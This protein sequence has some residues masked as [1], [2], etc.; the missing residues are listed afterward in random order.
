MAEDGV[1]RI[2]PLLTVRGG[3]DG[4]SA[5]HEVRWHA[6]GLQGDGMSVARHDVLMSAQC[7]AQAVWGLAEVATGLLRGEQSPEPVLQPAARR[8][9]PGRSAWVA[10]SA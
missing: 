5:V 2:E 7:P 4:G 6:V 1:A 10:S 3:N 9:V 8:G